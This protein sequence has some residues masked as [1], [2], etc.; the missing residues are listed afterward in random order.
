MCSGHVC[1]QARQKGGKK[2]RGKQKV[3]NTTEKVKCGYLQQILQDGKLDM[4]L[5]KAQLSLS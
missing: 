5:K 4:M 2:D 1:L 3:L